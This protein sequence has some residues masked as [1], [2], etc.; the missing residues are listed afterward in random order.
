MADER[1]A[2]KIIAETA[3]ATT[4]IEQIK[5]GFEGLAEAIRVPADLLGTFSSRLRE[6]VEL[7]GITYAIDKFREFGTEL[8]SANERLKLQAAKGNTDAIL[9]IYDEWLAETAQIYGKDSKEYVN[10]EREKLAAAQQAAAARLRIIEEEQRQEEEAYKKAAEESA[11][12]WRDA[13]RQ[14]SDQFGSLV[15]N[16]LDRTKTIAAAFRDLVDSLLKDFTKSLF[17]SLLGGSGDAGGG[18]ANLLFGSGGLSGALGLGSG[19]LFGLLGNALGLGGAAQQAAEV[20]AMWGGGGEAEVLAGKG[21]AAAGFGGLFSAIGSMFS[22]LFSFLGFA[23]GGIVP[24][25]ARG[26]VVPHFAN[27]GILSMLH[28]REMVLPAPISDGLQAMIA[29]GGGGHI[30]NLNISALDGRSV[31]DMGPRLVASINRAMRNGSALAVR[32]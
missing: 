19:G 4:G 5:E 2:V 20:A 30:F 29:N 8:F 22:G 11:R 32:S 27:G 28:Q 3:G 16:V 21:G 1:V 15:A 24:S 23:R 12:S 18:L 6:G 10:L 14:I 31:M 9:K 17:S 13:T 7:A 25:A 26:W